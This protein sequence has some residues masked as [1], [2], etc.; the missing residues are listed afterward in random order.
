MYTL[1]VII[2]HDVGIGPAPAELLVTAD[3]DGL[4]AVRAGPAADAS[5]AGILA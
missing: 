2:A 4:A 1:Q 5:V 3:A